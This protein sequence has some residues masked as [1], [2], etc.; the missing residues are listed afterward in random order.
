MNWVSVHRY[1]IKGGKKMKLKRLVGVVTTLSMVFLSVSTAFAA[2]PKYEYNFDGELGGAKVVV[3]EGDNEDGGNAGALPVESDVAAQ[4]DNGVNGQALYLD[5]KYGVLLDAEAVGETYTLAFWVNPARFS[6]FGPI[7]QL[8]S[9]LL[10]ANASAKWLN[11]T[12]TD[13]DGDSAPIIWSRNEV[14]DTFPWYLKAYFTADGG[15]QIPKNEWSHIAVTVDGS[16]TGMDPVLGTEVDGT[17]H[18]QLYINGELIGEGPVAEG[19][20]TGDA[21]VYL[22]I[23]AWDIIFKGLFDEFKIYDTV[24]TAV[25][26]KAAMGELEVTSTGTTTTPKTGVVSTGLFLGASALAFGTGAILFKKKGKEEN[27]VN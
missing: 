26:V 7:V 24:L 27:C 8:G 23:N 17:F 19:T 3:R 21:K 10:S 5:G 2:T 15:Y 20:F 9:D 16:K 12:K 11:I 4:F 6:N 18:S 25:D 13:W 14:L 1:Y 22:G